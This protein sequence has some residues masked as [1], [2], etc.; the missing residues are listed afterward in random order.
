VRLYAGAGIVGDSDPDKEWDET[1][2]KFKP[3]M[4]ALGLSYPTIEHRL[5]ITTKEMVMG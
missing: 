4:G 1:T 3:L 2:L 5:D